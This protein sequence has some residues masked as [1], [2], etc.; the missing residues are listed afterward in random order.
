MKKYLFLL[1]LLAVILSGCATTLSL[2]EPGSFSWGRP[3]ERTIAISPTS[4]PMMGC[5]MAIEL[6]KLGFV[7]V[8]SD[9]MLSLL[10]EL[11]LTEAQAL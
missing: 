1:P 6:P 9:Q 7:V 8:D 10:S 2:Y 5:Q 4:D 3:T 11:N